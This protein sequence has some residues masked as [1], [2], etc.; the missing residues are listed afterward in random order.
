MG[1]EHLIFNYS[2]WSLPTSKNGWERR[3][4]SKMSKGNYSVKNDYLGKKLSKEN[5]FVK[6]AD[7][8]QNHPRKTTPSKNTAL[9][10]EVQGELR[11]KWWLGQQRPR[12]E[13]LPVT[14]M[15]A[16]MSHKDNQSSALMQPNKGQVCQ[17][18]RKNL[19]STKSATSWRTSQW[20]IFKGLFSDQTMKETP[21]ATLPKRLVLKIS[22]YNCYKYFNH[23]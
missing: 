20:S 12:R 7:I 8:D 9:V 6:N 4:W 19:S 17:R 18:C 16:L 21:I 23:A 3:L 1:T 5:Y 11:K 2:Q 14:F 10:K 22:I 15:K 13:T